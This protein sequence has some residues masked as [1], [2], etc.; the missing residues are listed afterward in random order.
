[1]YAPKYGFGFITCA[2]KSQFIFIYI[3]DLCSSTTLIPIHTEAK[4]SAPRQNGY[5]H[6]TGLWVGGTACGCTR[7]RRKNTQ[8]RQLGAG[9]D[10][11]FLFPVEGVVHFGGSATN[12]HFAGYDEVARGNSAF[13]GTTSPFIPVAF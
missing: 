6:L 13:T 5:R 4:F 8:N 12:S 11:F 9:E 1:L 7:A 10:C 2:Y 3:V